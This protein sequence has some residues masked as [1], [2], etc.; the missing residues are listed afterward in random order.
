M[1]RMLYIDDQLAADARALVAIRHAHPRL[2]YNER[3]LT[4]AQTIAD[5]ADNHE[6]GAGIEAALE[7][8][9]FGNRAGLGVALGNA[10]DRA[11]AEM[12]AATAPARAVMHTSPVFARSLRHGSLI[13]FAANGSTV[14]RVVGS[15][16]HHRQHNGELVIRID[17]VDKH[18]ESTGALTFGLNES[19]HGIVGAV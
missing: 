14:Y 1:T 3:A 2:T 18:G 9:M 8:G 6:R 10:L 12:A 4:A 11:D 19:V 5:A 7:A 16:R 17:A 13:T 15:A